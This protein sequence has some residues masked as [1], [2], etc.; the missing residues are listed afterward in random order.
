MFGLA[1]AAVASSDSG[2]A[3]FRISDAEA[4]RYLSRAWT[5]CIDRA[6]STVDMRDCS[7]QE[8]TRLDRR[9]NQVYRDR[10]TRLAAP[11]RIRLRDAQRAWLR[12]RFDHC[13]EGGTGGTADL[14]NTDGCV[15]REVIRRIAWLERYRGS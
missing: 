1:G 11:A 4:D 12:V 5:V 3:G 14:L 15:Q 8:Y 7:S 2:Y 6:V 10:M 9:L 13:R